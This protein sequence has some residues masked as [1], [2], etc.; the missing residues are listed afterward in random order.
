VARTC[1]P[2]L[3]ARHDSNTN[4]PRCVNTGRICDGYRVLSVDSSK[5]R[6][7]KGQLSDK[8]IKGN[9]VVLLPSPTSPPFPASTGPL[10][11]YFGYFA[12]NPDEARNVGF[13]CH[14]AAHRLSSFTDPSFWHIVVGQLGSEPSIRRSIS[15]VS[16]IYERAER[17]DPPE[18]L[19]DDPNILFT[20][21]VAVNSVQ[22]LKPGTSLSTHLALISCV[23]FLCLEYLRGNIKGSLNHA[24]SGLRLIED[25]RAAKYTGQ[26]HTFLRSEIFN[27]LELTFCRLSLQSALFGKFS[28]ENVHSPEETYRSASKILEPVDGAEDHPSV[29]KVEEVSDA[30]IAAEPIPFASVDKAKLELFLFLHDAHA[31][32]VKSFESKYQRLAITM[33]RREEHRAILD[34][35][36][37]WSASFRRFLMLNQH[38]LSPEDS[39]AAKVL[40]VYSNSSFVWVASSL[41]PYECAYDQYQEQFQTIVDL[42]EEVVAAYFVGEDP[43]SKKI[44]LS[45]LSVIPPLHLTAWKCRHLPTRNKALRILG[46]RHW[47]EGMFDSH[48]SARCFE[49]VAEVEEAAIETKD[50]MPPEWVRIHHVE[51]DF[52][53]A[54]DSLQKVV[55][56]SKP[57]GP[58]GE[59][60]RRE[61]YIHL[62]STTELGASTIL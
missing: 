40:E 24:R 52:E 59:W 15:A 29:A 44:H 6:D 37:M 2:F 7:G 42:C 10:L 14:H 19:A 36:K 53:D 58:H 34:R 32:G 43:H 47:R 28:I 21:N 31:L 33:E 62:T 38:S 8:A 26:Q 11:D 23:L 46:S 56:F 27:E 17:G 20:Y 4:D 5:K 30:T 60:L 45:H 12:S 61:V 22:N 16:Q 55:F 51:F 50:Q 35:F 3:P 1:P 25:L 9:E 57:D 49:K 13:F 54:S 18:M 39:V 48:R 41:E